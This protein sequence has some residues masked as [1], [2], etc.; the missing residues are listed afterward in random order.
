[1]VRGGVQPVFLVIF[2]KFNGFNS[3]GEVLIIDFYSFN[4]IDLSRLGIAFVTT[5]LCSVGNTSIDKV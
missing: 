2:F 4:N 1:L 3:Q 5:S